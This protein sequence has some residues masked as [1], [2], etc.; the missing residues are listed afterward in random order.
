MSSILIPDHYDEK[1]TVIIAPRESKTGG[2]FLGNEDGARDN[3]MLKKKKVTAVLTISA[4]IGS[5]GL[6]QRLS[7]RIGTTCI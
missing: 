4:E 5:Y 1:L 2:L 6:T 3:E 7:L